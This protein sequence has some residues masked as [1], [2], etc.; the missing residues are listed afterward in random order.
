[1]S[2]DLLERLVRAKEVSSSGNQLPKPDK[3]TVFDDNDLRQDRIK[4]YL[5]SVD[6]GG[7]AFA[8]LGQLNSFPVSW[9]AR[10]ALNERHQHAGESVAPWRIGGLA[11]QHSVEVTDASG[12]PQGSVLGPILFLIYID[13]S[14]RGLDCDTAMFV[15][16]IKL[17]NV[18]LN[19]DDEANLQANL[20]RLVLWSSHW[21]HPFNVA[22]RDVLRI[23]RTSSAHREGIS[24]PEPQEEAND[25]FDTIPLG[26][27]TPT[28]MPTVNGQED[29]L[30]LMCKHMRAQSM[31]LDILVQTVRKLLGRQRLLES[32]IQQQAKTG[33]HNIDEFVKR[34]FFA[35]FD[36]EISLHVNFK[37]R[38]TKESLSGSKLYEVIL[39]ED[40]EKG[41]SVNILPPEE[42]N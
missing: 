28:T 5:V 38:K 41:T 29:I 40:A 9:V 31:K 35:V 6:E 37:G 20:D 33:G 26:D 4:V 25:S 13:D 19:E 1:M 2:S 30:L 34:I 24:S 27:D 39:D 22:K 36:D 23:G 15:D 12:V 17:W 11:D 7:R 10:A 8:I 21:L 16:D 32:M 3:L 42:Q 14:V 18:I